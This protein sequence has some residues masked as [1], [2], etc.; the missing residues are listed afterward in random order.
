[1][2]FYCPSCVRLE[3]MSD[4]QIAELQQA[5]RRLCFKCEQL[6]AAADRQAIIDHGPQAEG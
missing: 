4:K 1:M 5:E 3:R 6:N 2:K